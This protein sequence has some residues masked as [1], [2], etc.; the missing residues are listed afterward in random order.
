MKLWKNIRL[1][2]DRSF[3]GSWWKQLIWLTGILGF[4]LSLFL[5]LNLFFIKLEEWRIV[6]LF[7]DP[8][9]FVSNT[10]SGNI[11]FF[12]L[13][14]SVVGAA[15]F[16]GMLI[17]VFSNM[18]QRRIES[19][20]K[21]N[22]YYDFKDHFVILGFDDSVPSIIKQICRDNKKND[23]VLQ[24]VLEAESVRQT[25]HTQL[26]ISDE[27]RVIIINSRRDYE[28]ELEKLR[29]HKAKEIFL[30]GEKNEFDHDSLNIDCLKR[31]VTICKKRNRTEKLICNTLLQYQSTFTLF[32]RT[33]YSMYSK[34]EIQRGVDVVK[35]EPFNFSK[36]W[37]RKVFVTC[38]SKENNIKYK[39][40]DYLP[41]TGDSEKN[42]HLVV[43]GMTNM[44]IALAIQA[45]L[46]A[47]Y[48]NFITK[49][50]RSCIT[51]IDQ[52]A[53]QH[54]DY[55]LGRYRHL[56]NLCKYSFQEFKNGTGE[57]IKTHSIDSKNDF[58][59]LEW[60][61]IQGNVADP[62]IQNL[63]NLWSDR[64]PETL[65]TIA[66]CFKNPAK[67][68]AAGFCLPEEIYEK[69]CSILIQQDTT[70]DIIEML[71]K[72]KYNNV[73]PFGMKN[74]GHELDKTVLFWAKRINYLYNYN[75][76][77]DS[78]PEE[79]PDDEIE[80]QWNVLPVVKKWS[81]LYSADMIPS[82]LRSMGID[83]GNAFN[84]EKLEED[85]IE[86]LSK[87][88]H[89][90]WNVEELLLGYRPANEKEKEEIKNN[91][92]LKGKY[93]EKCIHYDIRPYQDLQ[94]D[95]SGRNVSRYDRAITEGLLKIIK[96][97]S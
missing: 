50:K 11:R 71:E 54:M 43:V 70:G 73:R 91:I 74:D 22:I 66:F 32:Q 96:Q 87:V 64:K 84:L 28:E 23:I 58:I 25:L 17:S 37:A 76:E 21:G 75:Y 13:S 69:E 85:Q 31:I 79:F 45:A 61:F 7:I 8:G 47:H 10:E 48:P 60:Q 90:R 46:I 39:P 19:I 93:R 55:L 83:L 62:N 82:K 27:K 4:F 67:N 89:N 49:G 95:S 3:L 24:T 26:N 20:K 16:A 34:D 51:F 2:F 81:N 15:I 56:F 38:E 40:L 5:I 86:M 9:A 78:V 63:F 88:E 72:S 35:F 94:P 18:L 57:V 14:V 97:C 65:L 53:R 12:T 52:N 6:E 80:K 42:V 36:I 68:I 30:I 33:S 77:H 29:V 44:G 92:G 59:D 41:L 1:G